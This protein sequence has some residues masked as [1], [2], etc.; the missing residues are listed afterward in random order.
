MLI[1]GRS[2]FLTLV[3]GLTWITVDSGFA[4]PLP[5]GRRTQY[6]YRYEN[7]GYKY[8]YDTGKGAY[9]K[10]VASPENEVQGDY[11]YEGPGG[12]RIDV[13]YTAGKGGYVPDGVAPSQGG[14]GP[15]SSHYNPQESNYPTAEDIAAEQG[16]SDASYS[17]GYNAGDQSRQEVSDAQ[18]N[19]QGSYTFVSK[20]GATRKVDYEA[21]AEKGFVIKGITPVGG[22]GASVQTGPGSGVSNPD[23][24]YAF[25]YTAGDHTRQESADAKGNVVGSFS[26]VAKDDGLNRQLN[27]EAGA[28][29]GFIAA[30]SHLPQPVQPIPALG[31]AHDS[32]SVYSAQ[33]QGGYPGT[34]AATYY[35]GAQVTSGPTYDGTPSVTGP[36]Q[37]REYQFSYN[38]GDH[39]RYESSDANGNVVGSFSFVAKD[40]KLNRKVDYLSSVDKGFVAFGSH[41]PVPPVDTNAAA[42]NFY[43]PGQTY[44]QGVIPQQSYQYQSGAVH[45]QQPITGE[46][47]DGSYSFSY[48]AGDH[49]RTET[50]DAHGNVVGSFSFIAKDDALQRKLDYEAGAEKGFIARGDHL[51]KDSSPNALVPA[52]FQPS[53]VG[54]TTQSLAT[55]GM[56][57]P[58]S[59]IFT[60]SSDNTGG[61]SDGSYTFSYNAGDQSRT[62]T[63]DNS[64]NVRGSY[65]FVSKDDGIQRKVDYEAGSK[66]FVAYG[67]HLPLQPHV[68]APEILISKPG[69]ENKPSIDYDDAGNS[70]ASYSFSYN[71]GDHT[72]HE[73]SDAKGNVVGSFSFI[74]KDDGLNRRVDYES[75]AELGFLAKGSHL[76]QPVSADNVYAF[77]AGQQAL[78]AN[79]QNESSSGS[80]YQGSQH[81]GH[82]STDHH[83]ST[84]GSS[85]ANKYYDDG[86]AH[87]RTFLT[88]NAHHKF[89][90][91]Y[92]TN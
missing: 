33:V 3:L 66:G 88:P 72:R 57:V 2:L 91:I 32:V 22:D 80:Y 43:S 81:T 37:G 39:T 50:S 20:D 5:T 84:I 10:A 45:Q 14:G 21:G 35:T 8:G 26:F 89:G 28:E 53:F 18:G 51:P 82:T 16:P 12:S 19:I 49:T 60:P 44:V 9:S 67:Q 59:T 31:G 86:K 55:Q 23:G 34:P 74:A 79:I 58:A 36:H 27:Y 56:V 41:L 68:V 83:S 29:K 75:G 77:T 42:P 92:D 64:G 38:A 7:G 13:K 61:V 25:S 70:D 46:N 48:N 87:V 30:G 15:S 73:S 11:A 85:S 65:S 4:P 62:E 24:S 78:G 40:D 54:S 17:F 69:D 76:P 6:Y 63:S 47:D 52:V 71:A 1:L 90:Y